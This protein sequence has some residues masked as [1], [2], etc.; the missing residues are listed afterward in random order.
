MQ[1]IGEVETEAFLEL[2]GFQKR[3]KFYDFYH[4]TSFFML[5]C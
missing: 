2:T 1:F 5:D 4:L 3:F